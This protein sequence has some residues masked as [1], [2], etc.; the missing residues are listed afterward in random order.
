[1][2]LNRR[3]YLLIC[4]VFFFLLLGMLGQKGELMAMTMPILF[5]LAFGILFATEHPELRIEKEISDDNVI[6]GEPV[7]IKIDVFNTGPKIEELV[8]EDELPESLEVSDNQHRLLTDLG[9][10]TTASWQYTVQTRRG[11]YW[12]KGVQAVMGESFGIFQKTVHLPVEKTMMVMPRITQLKQVAIRPRRT[13]VYSGIIPAAKGGSGTDFFGIREYQT[14]DSPRLINWKVSA[15]QVDELF[16]NEF[17]QERVADVG[18]IVDN[19]ARSYNQRTPES[20]LE[21]TISATAALA[22]SLLRDGNR[23][24]MLI[25]GGFMN[26]TFPG[27]GKLQRERILRSLANVTSFSSLVFNKID[28]IPTRLFPIRSQIIYISPLQKDDVETLTSLRSFGYHLLVICPDAVSFEKQQLESGPNLETAV[29]LKQLERASIIRELAQ[30]RI[31]V[32]NWDV[33]QPFHHTVE[34]T[35]HRHR[36]QQKNLKVG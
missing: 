12:M 18:L 36:F 21:H 29:R 28:R 13:R 33:S 24:G 35:L 16:T 8:L 19:R 26:W 32:I 10:D 6:Q 11:Y 14:G 7:V 20:L 17:E 22:D 34:T 25:Y 23:V 2:K 31:Q 27:S 1:M 15:R 4:L 9:E 30:A 3:G 5:Y